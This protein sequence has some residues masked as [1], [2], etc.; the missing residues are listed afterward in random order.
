MKK[1]KKGKNINNLK[2]ETINNDSM[3]SIIGN[4]NNNN[5]NSNFVVENQRDNE[6]LLNQSLDYLALNN[7]INCKVYCRLPVNSSVNIRNCQ[8][9]TIK[10]IAHQVK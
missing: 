6:I 9:C 2:I 8:D 5:C 7:L 4:E 10:L 3:I 1:E